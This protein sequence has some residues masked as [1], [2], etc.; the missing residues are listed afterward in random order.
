MSCVLYVISFNNLIPSGST[1]SFVDCS[2]NTI[3]LNVNPGDVFGVNVDSSNPPLPDENS[4]I[5]FI[6]K[7][8]VQQFIDCCSGESFGEF[9]F[10]ECPSTSCVLS[11]PILYFSD[12]EILESSKQFCLSFGESLTGDSTVIISAVKE[13]DYSGSDCDECISLFP[14]DPTPRP[15]PTPTPTIKPVPTPK[16]FDFVNECSVITLFPMNVDC[17]VIHPSP[18]SSDG[19]ASL[20]ITGGTPPYTIVW[21]N[22]NISPIIYNLSAGSYSATISDFY[23]DFTA[24]TTCVLTGS[25]PTPSPT[26]TPT[27]TSPYIEYDLCMETTLLKG[28]IYNV[29]Q[30]SFFPDVLFNSRPS[31]VNGDG[32]KKIVWDISVTPNRWILSSSTPSILVITNSNPVYPPTSGGWFVLG[33]GSNSSV[34]VFSGACEGDIVPAMMKTSLFDNDITPLTL[35]INK[36]ET[37]CG[38][39]GGVTILANGGNPP[40]VYSIDSGLT[41]KNFPIFN[42]LCSGIYSV[43]VI[44]NFGGEVNST[45]TLL[46]PQSPKT[47]VV[48]LVTTSNVT[49]LGSLHKTIEYITTINVFPDLP[50]NVYI[51]LDLHHSNISKSSPNISSSTVNVNSSLSV[52]DSIIPYDSYSDLDSSVSN[53]LPGCQL[54][55]VYVHSISETWSNLEISNNTELTLTTITNIHKNEDNDCYIGLSDDTYQITNLSIKGCYCCNVITS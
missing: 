49:T 15:T 6:E 14:C 35:N 24:R 4:K 27:P 31:W 45:F 12:G 51:N 2:G 16:V 41:Y 26:P 5:Q 29:T 54:D 30:T 42:D 21:D 22:G 20:I 33:G 43:K 39:D 40:Y 17:S 48:S 55:T 53:T 46:P 9:P 19:V 25:T 50:E 44:D 18:K 3:T 23:G 38:C 36:N 1:Y 7:S 11:T 47:Y 52:N 10:P 32:S 8:I 28:D 37:L 34:I 13:G